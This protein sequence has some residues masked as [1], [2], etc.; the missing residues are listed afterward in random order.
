M[1]TFWTN[2]HI[3]HVSSLHCGLIQYDHHDIGVDIC[4]FFL[5][6]VI[7]FSILIRMVI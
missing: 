1:L 6:I 2:V 3:V 4:D 7:L 5:L